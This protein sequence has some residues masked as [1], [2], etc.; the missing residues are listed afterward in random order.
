MKPKL[1]MSM[2]IL[3]AIKKCLTLVIIQLSQKY[4]DNNSNKLVIGKMKDKT[5]DVTVLTNINMFV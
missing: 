1:K 4:C 2:Q 3:A 5:G